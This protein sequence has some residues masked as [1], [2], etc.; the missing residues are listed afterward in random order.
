MD[1]NW[2]C[3]APRVYSRASG[4]ERGSLWNG[5]RLTRPTNINLRTH[6]PFTQNKMKQRIPERTKTYMVDERVLF[7]YNRR[8]AAPDECFRRLTWGSSQAF[9]IEFSLR[10]RSNVVVKSFTSSPA[11]LVYSTRQSKVLTKWRDIFTSVH[12]ATLHKIFGCF[13][14]RVIHVCWRGVSLGHECWRDWLKVCFDP[15]S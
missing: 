9:F 11:A 13:N 6:I 2:D 8:Q 1:G 5:I 10:M 3:G 12:C 7:V 15:R 4:R 14:D